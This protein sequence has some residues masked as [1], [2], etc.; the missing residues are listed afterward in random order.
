MSSLITPYLPTLRDA[1]RRL[2]TD[3]M[4]VVRNGVAVYEAVPCRATSNRL[5]AEPADPKDANMR[6]MAEWGITYPVSYDLAVGDHLTIVTSL[7]TI[8]VIVGEVVEGDTWQVA[9]RAWGNRPKV[10]TPQ[11]AV[12]IFRFDYDSEIWQ[13][14]P[15]QLVNLVY[16]RNQPR[17]TPVRFAPGGHA[18]YQGGWLIGGPDFDV[19]IEDRFTIDDIGAVIVE[20]LPQQPQ[21]CEARFVMDITGVR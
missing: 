11:I 18:S 20:V 3:R 15:E 12:T 1:Q 19:Q 7:M 6:S 5:F 8:E 13:E 17:S 2:M 16:D 10:A 21:R 4:D 14:L 9:G